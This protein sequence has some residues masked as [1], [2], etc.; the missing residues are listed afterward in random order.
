MATFPNLFEPYNGNLLF[1]YTSFQSA[2]RILASKSIRF[3]CFSDFNDVA[4]NS[5]VII[6]DSLP[7]EEEERIQ[8]LFNKY[9]SISFTYGS[10]KNPGFALET[11]WGYYGE[12]G[13]GACLVFKKDTLRKAFKKQFQKDAVR[14]NR[15]KYVSLKTGC[16]FCGIKDLSCDGTRFGKGAIKDLFFE[17]NRIWKHEREYRMLVYADEHPKSLL[18]NPEDFIGVITFCKVRS[19]DDIPKTVE[20]KALLRIIGTGKVF[21]LC[22]SMGVMTLIDDTGTQIWTTYHYADGSGPISIEL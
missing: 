10:N 16:S 6:G 18:L 11:Q 9:Y 12:K 1:H 17:K 19:L 22:D 3:G 15:I 14:F 4:E 20:Y 13:H 2:I 7:S 21:R 5:K 8:G